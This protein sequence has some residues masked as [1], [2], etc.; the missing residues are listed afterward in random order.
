M[1]MA[2]NLKAFMKK[3]LR[4][5]VARY[6]LPSLDQSRSKAIGLIIRAALGFREGQGN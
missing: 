6:T 4:W 2:A 5:E 1:V 3:I